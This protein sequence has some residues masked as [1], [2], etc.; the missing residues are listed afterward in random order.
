[1]ASKKKPSAK[2]KSAAKAAPEAKAPDA[3]AKAPDADAKAE[4]APEA[5]PEP[6]PE[7]APEP[8]KFAREA[9][10]RPEDEEKAI[11]ALLK[12]GHKAL[13]TLEEVL[14]S[15][16][17]GPER[18]VKNALKKIAEELDA[19][20]PPEP[21]K[22]KEYKRAIALARKGEMG[23]HPDDVMRFC[24]CSECHALREKAGIPHPL[25]PKQV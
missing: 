22:C 20:A 11:R 13:E 10:K 23:I 4:P 12:K 17:P 19:L 9:D 25:A 18:P 5:P 24:R 16:E 6:E 3:E 1:M 15:F 8:V 7:P 14:G 21:R 2:K